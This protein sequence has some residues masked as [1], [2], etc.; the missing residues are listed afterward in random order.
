MLVLIELVQ[1]KWE[2]K[3]I[4]VLDEVFNESILD[5]GINII[6]SV[7]VGIKGTEILLRKSGKRVS[8]YQK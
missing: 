2:F 8:S 7:A 1:S 4:L 6:F 3:L 5:R